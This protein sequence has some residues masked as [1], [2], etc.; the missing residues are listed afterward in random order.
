[1]QVP[2]LVSPR[3]HQEETVLEFKGARLMQRRVCVGSCFGQAV[4]DIS[5]TLRTVQ[6]WTG[7]SKR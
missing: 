7:Y 2:G 6:I 5:G 4:K 1:M 3:S